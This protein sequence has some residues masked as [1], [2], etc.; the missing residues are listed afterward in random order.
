MKTKIKQE[1]IKQGKEILGP[2]IDVTGLG[3]NGKI[4][5]YEQDDIDP[6]SI[7]FTNASRKSIRISNVHFDHRTGKILQYGCN[8]GELVL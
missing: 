4:E 1:L 2:F 5:T 7:V 8:Y 6:I 3:W